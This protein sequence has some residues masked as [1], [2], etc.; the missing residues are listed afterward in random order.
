M[1]AGV[2]NRAELEMWWGARKKVPTG[3]VAALNE[4][5]N[6]NFADSY[7]AAVAG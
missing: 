6:T 5:P 1:H 2:Q 4:C 3:K 7:M